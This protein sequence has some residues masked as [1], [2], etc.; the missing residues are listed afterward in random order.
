MERCR[1]GYQ[2]ELWGSAFRFESWVYGIYEFI[3]IPLTQKR[4]QHDDSFPTTP[5]RNWRTRDNMRWIMTLQHLKSKESQTY[6]SFIFDFM[7]EMVQWFL[8]TISSFFL[9]PNSINLFRNLF[10]DHAKASTLVSVTVSWSVP[11]DSGGLPV[12]GYKAAD[13]SCWGPLLDP[14]SLSVGGKKA[15]SLIDFCSRY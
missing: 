13:S 9:L 3:F 11:F 6:L 5:Q 12:L 2:F 10:L 7:V 8:Q 14:G 15:C 4:M 1:K